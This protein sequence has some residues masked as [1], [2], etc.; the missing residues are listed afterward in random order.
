MTAGMWKAEL[1]CNELEYLGGDIS[2]QRVLGAAWFL[3]AT[4]GKT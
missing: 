4:F 1:A 2:K 3:L